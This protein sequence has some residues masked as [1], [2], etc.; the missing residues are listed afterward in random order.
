M[1]KRVA[2]L[3]SGRG[4][5]FEALLDAVKAG[6]LEANI[7]L[8]LCD[9]REAPALK[10]A[11]KWKIPCFVVEGQPKQDPLQEQ[12]MVEVLE[13]HDIRFLVLAGYRRI[14]SSGF[15]QS[16]RSP[17]GYARITNIHPSLLPAFPGLHS[18]QRAFEYGAKVTGVTVHLVD[19]GVDQGPICAQESFEISSCQTAEEVEQRGLEIEH[20]LYPETLNWILQENFDYRVERSRGVCT[21]RSSG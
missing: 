13:S 4:S 14:L 15:I 12:R 8:L 1:M 6:A 18:Y 17:H 2:V 3:A 7:A 11:E 5:N 21:R 9:R 20:R 19:D 16:F 10:I